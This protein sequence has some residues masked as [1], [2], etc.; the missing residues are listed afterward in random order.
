MALENNVAIARKQKVF[1]APEAT[2]G[3]LAWPSTDNSL[4]ISGIATMN[5]QP[6]Y[7]DSDEIRETRGLRDRF[8][9]RMKEGDFSFSVYARPNGA[10]NDP[11]EALI[12]KGALGNQSEQTFSPASDL[13]S[14]SLFIL[15]DDRLLFAS[16]CGI[17]SLSMSLQNQ[18]AVKFD[19]SGKLLK[20]QWCGK[21]E[22]ASAA[23]AGDTTIQ[24]NDGSLFCVGAKIKIGDDDNSGNGYTI[25]SISAN[26]LTIDPGISAAASQGAVVEPF[27][28]Q[29][30]EVGKPV[31]ART[32]IVKFDDTEVLIT[33]LDFTITNSLKYLVDEISSEDYPQEWIEGERRITGKVSMYFRRENLKYFSKGL[34]DALVSLEM[35][36]GTADG[37]KIKVAMPKVKLSVPTISGDFERILEMDFVAL[38]TSGNDEISIQYL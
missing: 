2:K 24:V 35:D 32:G 31:S 13:P 7:I 17:D 27:L 18:G 3:Q 36:A 9:T 11:M 1:L 30:Q 22:L 15:E 4:V 5:Q 10:G 16:G 37:Y 34:Q 6:D 14:L 29:W 26:T 8:R 21:D 12:L 20:M 33:G 23:T 38:E 28:P 19:I 25:Q